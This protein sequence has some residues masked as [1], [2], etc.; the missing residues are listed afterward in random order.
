MGASIAAPISKH[1]PFS[2]LD[3]PAKRMRLRHHLQRAKAL[4]IQ[5]QRQKVRLEKVQQQSDIILEEDMASDL[6]AVMGEA[7]SEVEKLPESSF[8]RMFWEQQ[9]TYTNTCTVTIESLYVHIEC[10]CV[11]FHSTEQGYCYKWA[12]GYEMASTHDQVVS[13]PEVPIY[14]CLQDN[15]GRSQ[16]AI[17]EDPA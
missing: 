17:H 1:T 3:T 4:A 6:M 5:V 10:T 12:K 9:V 2:M 14:C 8:K 16:V 11:C 7:K 15:D 13:L